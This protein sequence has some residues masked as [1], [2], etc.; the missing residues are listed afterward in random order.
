[1]FKLYQVRSGKFLCSAVCSV[2]T[3]VDNDVNR[4][5]KLTNS[6]ILQNLQRKI[7]HLTVEKKDM[8]NLLLEFQQIFPDVPSC[9]TCTYHD[10]DVRSA[11]PCKQHPY[12]VNP[13]KLQYLWK[14]V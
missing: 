4:G 6:E 3:E 12:R 1:M 7:F 8:K 13:V 14:E 10:V 5:P 11:L 2:A 9:T